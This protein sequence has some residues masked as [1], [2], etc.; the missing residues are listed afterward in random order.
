MLSQC[1]R[2]Q[3]ACDIEQANQGDGDAGHAGLQSTQ[4]DFARQMRDQESDMEAAGEEPQVQQPV[5]A[6]AQ[7]NVQLLAQGDFICSACVRWCC[8][9]WIGRL[10]AQRP[11]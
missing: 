10:A 6:V 4:R 2:H 5:T 7:G 1:T 8:G 3:A 11:R 9:K